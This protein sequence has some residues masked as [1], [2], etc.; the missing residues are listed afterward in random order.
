MYKRRFLSSLFLF[1]ISYLTLSKLAFLDPTLEELEAL[2][3]DFV[4]Q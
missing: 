1:L 3:S 4:R 2:L